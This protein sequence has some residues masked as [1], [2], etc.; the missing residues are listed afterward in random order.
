MK[1]VL[2]LCNTMLPE[3][4]GRF[5]VYNVK[6]GWLIGI[7]QELRKRD[8]IELHY[9][10]PQVN[11]KRIV[12]IKKDSI[13]FHCFYKKYDNPYTVEEDAKNQ[14]KKIINTV[15]PDIIHIFGTEMSHT[16]ECVESVKAKEKIVISIQGL[17]SEYAK[18][19]L[20]GIPRSAYLNGCIYNGKY[21]T[22]WGQYKEFCKRAENEIRA[23]KN[24]KHV[25]GRTNWDKACT[26]TINSNCMYHYC[27]E[28]L[29]DCFYGKN[30]DIQKIDRYSIFVSQGD[31][32]IKG[33][34]TLLYAMPYIL[35]RFP[36]TNL[37]IA[38]DD[39]FLNNTAYG[40]YIKKLIGKQK[41]DKAVHFLGFIRAE[42]MCDRMQ[43]SHVMVLPSNCENS[44]NSVGEAMLVGLPIVA[45]DVGGV[46]SI[47]HHG[48]DAILFD[49]CDVKKL[50]KYV[51]AI[52]NNDRF[53][54]RL[55]KNG[56]LT[57]VKLYDPQK[58]VERLIEIYREINEK[59]CKNE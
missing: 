5:R 42:D 4:F 3:L 23:I 20:N 46:S 33:L 28:T 38:G 21:Q 56:N 26:N 24:V 55:S 2:W 19:Y 53:A 35:N 52:F 1:K 30:W 48:W 10:C 40:K 41:L 32:P 36:D 15:Q 9:A 43:K 58:N 39:S 14:I 18:Y 45:A 13:Y 7:S 57:A 29:R 47:A 6:E 49:S 31:Y 59:R 50:A 17:V 16:I 12:N 11:E 54:Q 27:S 51:C 22:I 44:P 37:Y 34:H 25:I 8:D